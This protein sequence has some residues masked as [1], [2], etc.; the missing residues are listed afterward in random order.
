MIPNF[1]LFTNINTK[2]AEQIISV[3][4]KYPC[5][6]D[7][8]FTSLFCWNTDDT[9]QVSLLNQNLV[10]K[11]PDY[12]TGETV[13]SILGDCNID[14]SLD[15]LLRIAGELRL[16]PQTVVSSMK[17]LEKYQV[18]ED[19]DNFDYIYDVLMLATLKGGDFKKKRNK[20]NKFKHEFGDLVSVVSTLS[21]SPNLHKEILHLFDRWAEGK[22]EPVETTSQERKAIE[23]LLTHSAKIKLSITELRLEN[24]LVGFSINEILRGG[25]AICHFEKAIPIHE[26]IYTFL[27]KAVAENLCD[28][29]VKL[30]NWEQDLGIPGLRKSKLNY[31]PV[32]MLKKYTIKRSG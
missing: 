25:Y 30:V 19:P 26:N 5:Y 24:Q 11:M 4:A 10:V 29:N 12:M 13:Y 9:S 27:A 17:K 7:F 18:T 31:Q 14:D 2:L 32:K 21:V 23:N 22:R 15:E 3:T 16:V 28:H 8:N 20:A 6:S 1:P